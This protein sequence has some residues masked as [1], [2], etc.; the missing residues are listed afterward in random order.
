[1]QLDS[2][3]IER[4]DHGLEDLGLH[5]CRPVVFA[6]D[7][8]LEQRGRLRF[9]S[10]VRAELG[11]RDPKACTAV[12]LPQALDARDLGGNRAHVGQQQVD[13]RRQRH[14]R[15]QRVLSIERE[16]RLEQRLGDVSVVHRRDAEGIGERDRADD[17]GF[18]IG[19]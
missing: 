14:A 10:T 11:R 15:M 17:P 19:F 9:E 7:V 16:V 3:A 6:A 18:D 5:H 12:L 13:L 2:R 8:R 4:D 1:M